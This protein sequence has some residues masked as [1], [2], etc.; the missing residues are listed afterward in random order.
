MW[1]GKVVA[2]LAESNGSILPGGWLK[3]TCGLTA[4]TPGSALSPTIGNEYRKTTFYTATNMIGDETITNHYLF[5]V[6]QL[7]LTK[8]ITMI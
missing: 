1:A 7:Y 2:D 8:K 5:I 6:F 4:Y 3:V